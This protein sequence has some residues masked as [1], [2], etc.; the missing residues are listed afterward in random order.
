MRGKKKI[1]S[2]K[3]DRVPAT[4]AE[5]IRWARRRSTVGCRCRIRR[6]RRPPPFSKRCDCG[7]GWSSDAVFICLSVI[8]VPI[9]P[10]S[11]RLLLL[12]SENTKCILFAL[13]QTDSCI[14]LHN[15]VYL[16]ITI[17]FFYNH[18]I[19]VLFRLKLMFNILKLFYT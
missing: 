8:C 18:N 10:R 12:F 13:F 9:V 7:S 15:I 3:S 4:T 14:R 16:P 6:H 5:T 17:L 11:L 2:K 1:Y 19:N